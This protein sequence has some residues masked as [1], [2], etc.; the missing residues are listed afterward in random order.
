MASKLAAKQEEI[1][2][3]QLTMERLAIDQQRLKG[4]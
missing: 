4:P 1:Q 3:H 2:Q